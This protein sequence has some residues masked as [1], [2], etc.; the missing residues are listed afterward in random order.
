M[1]IKPTGILN[2]SA[3]SAMR[4]EHYHAKVIGPIKPNNQGGLNAVKTKKEYQ[5]PVPGLTAQ[6]GLGG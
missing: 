5:S 6:R 4:S 3:H 1:T 2:H